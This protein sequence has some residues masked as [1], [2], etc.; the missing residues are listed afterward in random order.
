MPPPPCQIPQPLAVRRRTP[1]GGLPECVHVEGD[2]PAVR[3]RVA[4]FMGDRESS[5]EGLAFRA[6]RVARCREQKCGSLFV[7][8]GHKSRVGSAL[9]RGVRRDRYWLLL[10]LSRGDVQCVELKLRPG[11][12]SVRAC[13]ADDIDRVGFEIDHWR[14]EDTP[15]LVDIEELGCLAE[16]VVPDLRAQA[17]PL[18]RCRHRRP[19]RCSPS[20]R[21]IQYR[22]VPDRRCW[23]P[24]TNKGW[25]S[26]RGSSFTSRLKR[27][28]SILL[29]TSAGVR[30]VSSVFAPVRAFVHDRVSTFIFAPLQIRLRTLFTAPTVSGVGLR[31]GRLSTPSHSASRET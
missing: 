5:E 6:A 11:E 3:P 8:R 9:C 13:P 10:R 4:R 2:D 16:G 17:R 15:E 19:I 26:I 31:K 14:T 1:R 24:E 29:P 22:E 27:L 30:T 12:T 25:A 23:T 7:T 20:C 28:T 21:R 18:D